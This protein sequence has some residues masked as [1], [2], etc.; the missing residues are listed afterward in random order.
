M[1]TSSGITAGA[2][3]DWEWL[4]TIPTSRWPRGWPFRGIPMPHPILHTSE[5][6]TTRTLPFKRPYLEPHCPT[7]RI[8]LKRGPRQKKGWEWQ[9][10]SSRKLP[11]SQ[12]KLLRSQKPR[13]FAKLRLRKS[14][15]TWKLRRITRFRI[16][17]PL[18]RLRDEVFASPRQRKPSNPLVGCCFSGCWHWSHYLRHCGHRFFSSTFC[19]FCALIWA[20]RFSWKRTI[21]F[22]WAP[23]ALRT[24][25]LFIRY[26]RHALRS[27]RV[28]SSSFSQFPLFFLLLRSH[29][30]YDFCYDINYT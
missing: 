1:G 17:M 2:S 8:Y 12:R 5:P 30:N 7:K 11:Q 19:S 20:N 28:F 24:D 26:V 27:I 15:L 18:A 22:L 3:W 25:S 16:L 14:L 29:R 9:K 23:R 10:K 4:P 6:V 21:K 13:P